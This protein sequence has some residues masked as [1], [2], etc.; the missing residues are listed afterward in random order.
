[1]NTT[2]TR[3]YREP[4]M[5]LVLFLP[6]AAFAAGLVTLVLAYSSPDREVPRAEPPARIVA[7]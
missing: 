5:W 2:E 1:M 7:P 6:T 3:W 4:M